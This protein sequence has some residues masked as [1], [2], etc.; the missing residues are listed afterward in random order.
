V[1]G[2]HAAPRLPEAQEAGPERK[3]PAA[4]HEIE[5]L[6]VLLADGPLVAVAQS[7]VAPSELEHP[8]LRL[9]LESLYRLH[10]EGLE[11]GLDHLQGRIDN[12]RLLDKARELMELGLTKC[13]RHA[14]LQTILA[15]FRERREL[16]RTQELKSQVLAAGDHQAALRLLRQ[17]QNKKEGPGEGGQGP[18]G[19]GPAFTGQEPKAN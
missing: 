3:A 8:G 15:R 17:L 14:Y 5:L 4:K 1:N 18:P 13:D 6:E 16:R 11:P 19:P 9:L 12:E 10:A 2:K 7:E